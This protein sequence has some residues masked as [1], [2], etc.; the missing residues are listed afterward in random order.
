MS[1]RDCGHAHPR[2]PVQE[3][4]DVTPRPCRLGL[5]VGTLSFRMAS[6]DIWSRYLMSARREL[7]CATMSTCTGHA[8]CSVRSR[9]READPT[10]S[11]APRAAAGPPLVVGS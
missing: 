6:S 9:R 2:R 5:P 3:S 10:Q 7:P 11:I 8:P 1:W 4:A